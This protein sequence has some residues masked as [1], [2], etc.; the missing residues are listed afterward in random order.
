MIDKLHEIVIAMDKGTN[1]TIFKWINEE[2]NK[3]HITKYFK[4]R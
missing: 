1:W 2:L 4:L 3:F